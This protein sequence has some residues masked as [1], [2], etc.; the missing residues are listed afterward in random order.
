MKSLFRI[1]LVVLLLCSCS[2]DDVEP[3]SSFSG[4][5]LNNSNNQP[6][7][8]G[9]IRIIGYEGS[10]FLRDGRQRLN[11]ASRTDSEGRFDFEVTVPDKVGYMIIKVEVPGAS[12]LA[13]C[14]LGGCFGL[15]PGKDYKG[16]TLRVSFN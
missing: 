11:T 13:D 2:K 15:K 14:S 5:L 6:I 8:D 1:V 9:V 7:I 12:V 16:L 10:F 4:I 3:V